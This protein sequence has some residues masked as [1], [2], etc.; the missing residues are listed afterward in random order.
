MLSRTGVATIDDITSILPPEERMKQ[1]PVAIIECFQNIPCNP[2][3]TSCAKK[4]IKE[5]SD[6]NDRPVIDY[7]KCNGCGTCISNC[8]GLAIFVVDETYSDQ[9]ALIK[10]PYEF[11]PLPSKGQSVDALDREGNKVGKARVVKVQKHQGAG[12]DASHL[13]CFR[14]KPVSPGPEYWNK[15]R[16]GQKN[17]YLSL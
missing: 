10:I 9:E 5:F 16:N 12:P 14:K 6:I 4:A 8:P 2:C 7:D 17:G 1:G 3:A 11:T 13:H 15:A